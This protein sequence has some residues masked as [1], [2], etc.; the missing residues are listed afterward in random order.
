MATALAT[1]SLLLAFALQQPI[2]RESQPLCPTH[3]MHMMS[4][5]ERGEKGMGFSQMA[6]T[7]HF[8]LTST[9][10]AIVVQ[11]N[12]SADSESRDEIRMHLQHIQQA[13]QNGDFDIPMFVHSTVPPGVA[14][15]KQRAKNIRYS[16]EETANG[17]RVIILTT[18]Q[19]ALRAIHSFLRF[20]ITE[21]QTGDPLGTP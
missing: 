4:L 3:D 12:S 8:L 7:H 10:G 6:T 15:M 19:K 20:Q 17:G 2:P 5:N 1:I 21:H 18:D 11:A 9:G 16:V 14:T 13:F